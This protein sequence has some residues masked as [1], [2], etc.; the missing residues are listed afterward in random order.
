MSVEEALTSRLSE[1][2]S[3]SFQ[4]KLRNYYL[5]RRVARN[6]GASSTNEA[7]LSSLLAA[8]PARAPAAAPASSPEPRREARPRGGDARRPRARSSS[9]SDDGGGGSGGGGARRRESRDRRRERRW[10][11]GHASSNGGRGAAPGERARVRALERA[12]GTAEDARD[13]AVRGSRSTSLQRV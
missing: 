11:R 5:E 2:E 8:A 13:G 10:D 9:D 12:L 4:L 7:E 1:L 6:E 3:D